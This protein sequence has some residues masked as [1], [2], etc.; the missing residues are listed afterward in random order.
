[1]SPPYRSPARCPR[2]FSLYSFSPPV[3][4]IIASFPTVCRAK[5][6]SRSFS[7]K[8]DSVPGS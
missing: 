6:T 3:S 8:R 7:G 5:D 2:A 4:A 1:M